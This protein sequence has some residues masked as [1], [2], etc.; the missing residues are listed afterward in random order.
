MSTAAGE[1]DGL[2]EQEGSGEPDGLGEH[3]GLGEH[4]A[5]A[6]HDG[7]GEGRGRLSNTATVSGKSYRSP[8][9]T[10]DAVRMPVEA[11]GAASFGTTIL[12]PTRRV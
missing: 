6:V 4:D 10:T 1:P 5:L 3:E 9:P 7:L 2:G 12:T 11:P 8:V